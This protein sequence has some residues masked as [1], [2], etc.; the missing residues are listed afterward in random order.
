M[1]GIGFQKSRMLR[2]TLHVQFLAFLSPRN[3]ANNPLLHNYSRPLMFHS[4][5]F[6]DERLSLLFSAKWAIF[7]VL[8]L[9]SGAG[10]EEESEEVESGEE[11]RGGAYL[12]PMFPCL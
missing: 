6:R 12:R 3:I 2:P 9:R 5:F 4:V 8:T 7:G 11:K 1:V 10:K